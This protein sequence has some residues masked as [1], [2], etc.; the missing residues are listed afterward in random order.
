MLDS[1]LRRAGLRADTS[2]STADRIVYAN[3][4]SRNVGFAD[5]LV[6][7]CVLP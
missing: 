5:N 2:V 4:P 7:T 3:Q 6:T 1:T